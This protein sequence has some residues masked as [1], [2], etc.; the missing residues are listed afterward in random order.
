MAFLV[1]QRTREIGIRMAMG[2]TSRVVL[3]SV[4][5]QGLRPVLVA[6]VVGLCGAVRVL[7]L[8]EAS[9]VSKALNLFSGASFGPA[10][11]GALALMLA[12]SVLAS[13]IPA[14]RAARVDPV[15]ALRH[16]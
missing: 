7:M 10:L 4:V 6:T 9:E 12:I 8:A 13:A 16:E 14:R 5:I 15:V 2:A 1:S 3:R 11:C